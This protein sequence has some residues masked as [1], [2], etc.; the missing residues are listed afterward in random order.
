M[1]PEGV[2]CVRALA[3]SRPPSDISWRARAKSAV[4]GSEG[5]EDE[6]GQRARTRSQQP[7]RAASGAA[8]RLSRVTEGLY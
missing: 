5:R 7:L 3:F 2:L 1:S 4:R 6:N 8:E